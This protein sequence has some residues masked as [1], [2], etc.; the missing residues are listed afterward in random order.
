MAPQRRGTAPAAPGDRPPLPPRNGHLC[1]ALERSVT[2]AP[3]ASTATLESAQ[4]HQLS[5]PR[6]ARRVPCHA[7]KRPGVDCSSRGHKSGARRSPG[8]RKSGARRSPGWKCDSTSRTGPLAV[9]VNALGPPPRATLRQTTTAV[10]RRPPFALIP[11]V[12][13]S[14]TARSLP[15][16][17]A[18]L[19]AAARRPARPPCLLAIGTCEW[20]ELPILLVHNDSAA[21]K[22]LT[23]V[24]TMFFLR[25]TIS[26]YD[27]SG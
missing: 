11:C 5:R 8:G 10:R 17:C 24:K 25:A 26:T 21:W 4:A 2:A 1:G 15:R 27:G 7:R 14:A 12:V 20:K 3:Q 9:D 22:Y 19:A 13:C 6:P 18:P 23:T 16:V